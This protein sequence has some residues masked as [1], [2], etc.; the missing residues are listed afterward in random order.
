MSEPCTSTWISGFSPA[1]VPRNY[2]I[3]NTIFLTIPYSRPSTETLFDFPD[4]R[5]NFSTHQTSKISGSSVPPNATAFNVTAF[6]MQCSSSLT[7]WFV[8]TLGLA[9][10]CGMFN[11]VFLGAICITANLRTGSGVLIGHLAMIETFMC[12]V[13]IP[14]YMAGVLVHSQSL[15]TCRFTQFF[16][17][18]TNTAG[19]WNILFL[20]VNRFVAVL[21]PLHYHTFVRR[22]FPAIFILSMWVMGVLFTIPMELDVNGGIG[23]NQLWGGCSVSEFK[24]GRFDYRFV[25]ST[26][27]TYVPLALAGLLYVVL[28]ITSRMKSSRSVTV[29]NHGASRSHHHKLAMSKMLFVSAIFYSLSFFAYPI[30]AKSM[31]VEMFLAHPM[32]QHW[33]VTVSVSGYA[34]HPV[35]LMFNS[36]IH[37]N[38]VR[39]L[40]FRIQGR[41]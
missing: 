40:L 3:L 25:Q 28:L 9:F 32:L 36:T 39:K 33:M 38:G 26:L 1:S 30:L 41:S 5:M 23:I 34:V 14:I 19:Y 35:F 7:I 21:Y 8:L 29:E 27:K 4:H 11:V 24:L 22:R 2:N 20:A 31:P 18:L 6:W 13:H 16:Y 15:F 10:A 17:S 37:R 12:L